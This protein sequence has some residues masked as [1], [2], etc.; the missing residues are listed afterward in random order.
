LHRG[1]FRLNPL[2]KP[3]LFGIGGEP[4]IALN[5]LGSVKSLASCV[6]EA[7]L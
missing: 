2:A 1:T 4:M 5:A 3:A 6:K 7:I